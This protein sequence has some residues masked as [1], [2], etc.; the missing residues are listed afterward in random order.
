MQTSGPSD[1]FDEALRA[2]RSGDLIRAESILRSLISRQQ[3]RVEVVRLLAA[4]LGQSNRVPEGL[5]LLERGCAVKPTDPDLL[6]DR[7]MFLLRAGRPHDALAS[8]KSAL[9]VCPDHGPANF[10]MGRLAC[11][12]LRPLQA[13]GYLKKACAA[14]PQNGEAILVYA[15]A[16]ALAGKY[17]EMGKAARQALAIRPDWVEAMALLAQSLSAFDGS[18]DEILSLME[19]ARQLRPNFAPAWTVAATVYESRREYEKAEAMMQEALGKCAMT[20]DMAVLI[21]RLA[22][23]SGK[24]DQVINQLQEVSER[25]GMPHAQRVITLFTLGKALESSKRYDDAFAVYRRCHDPLKDR[26]NPQLYLGRTKIVRETFGSPRFAGRKPAPNRGLPILIVGMPRSG[27]SLTEQI[28]GSHPAVHAAGELSTLAVSISGGLQRRFGLPAAYP[29]ARAIDALTPE[30]IEVCREEYLSVLRDSVPADKLESLL[31]VTDK[32]PHNF[33]H[34]GLA[35]MIVPD[36]VVVYTH[37]NPIDNCVSLY[38]TSL[39]QGHAYVNSFESLAATY[40]D[41]YRMMQHWRAV[42][43]LP[44]LDLPYESLVSD[45]EPTIRRLLDFVGLEF[46]PACLSHH[47]TKRIIRTASVDQAN[48]PIYATSAGRWRRYEKHLQPL[49]DALTRELGPFDLD[50]PLPPI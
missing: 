10:A 50:G 1:K 17:D 14:M 18:E 36:A 46:H 27:T 35:A 15:Q 5:A 24:L 45:P 40:A 29:D 20:P 42:L 31:R 34:L 48:K 7:G 37:R 44:I 39:N 26:F 33:I 16:C 30:M 41:H 28:L 3:A 19:K 32:M 47:E 25:P 13:I 8:F 2:F 11:D 21:E 23:R 43:P 4:V 9:A 38:T 6:A 12:D 22:E 49:I